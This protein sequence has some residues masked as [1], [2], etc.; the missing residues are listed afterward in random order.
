[1]TLTDILMFDHRDGLDRAVVKSFS[2]GSAL[3]DGLDRA[4]IDGS[5]VNL[6]SLDNLS[7]RPKAI[8]WTRRLVYW[9]L[10]GRHRSQ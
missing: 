2:S 7:S 3:P 5:M 8:E 10:D 4:G 1:M 6:I 9:D